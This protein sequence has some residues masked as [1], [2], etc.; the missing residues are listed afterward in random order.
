MGLNKAS[1]VTLN[2]DWQDPLCV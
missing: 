2:F 1:V